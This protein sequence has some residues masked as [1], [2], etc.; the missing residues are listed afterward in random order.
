MRLHG[1]HLDKMS[2]VNFSCRIVHTMAS[3]I[4]TFHDFIADR[5]FLVYRVCHMDARHVIQYK[6]H[7]LN[8]S[9]SSD[10][11]HHAKASQ[12]ITTQQEHCEM[13]GF[14]HCV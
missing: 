13:A 4:A 9:D 5:N 2:A 7:K 10:G 6:E 11:S 3:C 1:W 14:P 8:T 12:A